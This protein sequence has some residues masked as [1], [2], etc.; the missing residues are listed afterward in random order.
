[1]KAELNLQGEELKLPVQIGKL[2]WDFHV[3]QT[4]APAAYDYTG[5]GVIEIFS[6]DY[7]IYDYSTVP[8]KPSANKVTRLVLIPDDQLAYQVGRYSSGM[9]YAKY[10]EEDHFRDEAT[11]IEILWKR[12]T[13]QKEEF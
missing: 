11:L 7:D 4:S 13:N 8:Q 6:V 9:C 10:P 12:I 2:S 5:F 1:M 3:I